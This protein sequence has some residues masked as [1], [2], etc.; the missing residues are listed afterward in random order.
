MEFYSN[1]LTPPTARCN[2]CGKYT[3]E[4]AVCMITYVGA[5]PQQVSI[6]PSC[7]AAILTREGYAVQAVR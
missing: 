6:H 2:A 1:V 7:F 3:K 4:V 5:M